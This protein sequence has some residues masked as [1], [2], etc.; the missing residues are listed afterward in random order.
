[1]AD[2]CN[3]ITYQDVVK[4]FARARNPEKGKPLM[5]WARVYKEGEN[6]VVKLGGTSIGVFTPDNKFTFVMT[7]Q[8]ARG[9]SVTLSQALYRA[10]PF[11]WQRV[12]TGRYEVASTIGYKEW[13][14]RSNGYFWNFLYKSDAAKWYEV[15]DGL[16]FDLTTGEPT[17]AR[18]R[19][20]EM[21]VNS[22]NR[23]EWLRQLRKFKTAI[24]VRARMGVLE[25]LM[26]QVER[27]RQTINRHQWD[28][29]DW[30][31]TA[32]Q[33]MLYTSIKDNQCSTEL[34]KGLI[35][36]V[37]RGY[38]RTTVSV[39]DVVK[40]ADNLCK[41]YSI[42]LRKRFGVFDEVPELQYEDAVS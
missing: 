25:S 26:Q 14:E 31:S 3:A 29:P 1:M 32:W 38:W 20:T 15:F 2:I 24:K 13:Q 41:M 17:N 35:K 34:L 4:F 8:T 9:V 33:D 7:S 40:E 18:P 30:S 39:N 23:L 42:D 22:D 12:A 5:S 27:E 19:L 37:S 21:A 28:M 11:A 36:S 6:Y 16:T 10:L